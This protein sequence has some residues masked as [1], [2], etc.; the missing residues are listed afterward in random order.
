MR[1]SVIAALSLCGFLVGCSEFLTSGGV[2]VTGG[3]D[4]SR[5]ALLEKTTTSFSENQG[6]LETGSYYLALGVS[7][8]DIPSSISTC[9]DRNSFAKFA[10]SVAG[11]SN[12]GALA[13]VVDVKAKGQNLIT[14]FPVYL[15][16]IKDNP[17][18]GENACFSQSHQGVITP[19]FRHGV[20]LNFDITYKIKYIGKTDVEVLQNIFKAATKIAKVSGSTGFAAS[21]LAELLLSPA[22]EVLD[23]A[24]GD[25]FS[26]GQS[27]DIATLQISRDPDAEGVRKDAVKLSLNSV[28]PGLPS[29]AGVTVGLTYKRS[30]VGEYQ[31]GEEGGGR[32]SYSTDAGTLVTSVYDAKT[33]NS[34][35]D[36]V[37]NGDKFFVKPEQIVAWN[38]VEDIPHLERFCRDVTS[39]LSNDL[40]LTASDAL[41]MRWAILTKYTNYNSYP[42]IQ[43]PVCMTTPK[44]TQTSDSDLN[45][46]IEL[47]PKFR[48]AKTVSDINSLIDKKVESIH[49]A[50]SASEEEFSKY[51]DVDNFSMHTVSKGFLPESFRDISVSEGAEAIKTVQ[52]L[53]FKG[54]CAAKQAGS[55]DTVRAI[56]LFMRVNE[57]HNAEHPERMRDKKGNPIVPVLL[58]LDLESEKFKSMYILDPHYA[59]EFNISDRWPNDW[60]PP[61]K[62][63]CR[64]LED[65]KCA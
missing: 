60:H 7:E 11:V 22:T 58:H 10:N 2:D 53:F 14:E 29:G 23:K 21:S 54:F 57:K 52:N 30:L 5:T 42:V 26:D 8:V 65:A 13:I 37:S 36:V 44:H 48:F 55:I 12:V 20:N 28:F 1:I 35:D 63:C 38:R 4:S 18:P 62:S 51:F 64:N 19:Y 6:N 50:M 3:E 61:S 46:L 9:K 25:A 24:A 34:L 32:I 31:I 56:A 47:D 16:G 27:A 15:L 59:H 43:T 17:A 49:H 40:A 45:K 33:D 41:V 39:Y